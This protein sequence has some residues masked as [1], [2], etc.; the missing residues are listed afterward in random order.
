MG[1]KVIWVLLGGLGVLLV[2]G[3]LTGRLFAQSDQASCQERLEYAS[4]FG[5][6]L[7]VARHAVEVKLA[8]TEV[9]LNKTLQELN[10]LKAEI[11]K[12]AENEKAS[13][14]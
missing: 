5:N 2:I 10:A 3:A 11:A 12:K 1:K 6:D 9:T 14:K 7:V 13:K 4:Q 8:Q